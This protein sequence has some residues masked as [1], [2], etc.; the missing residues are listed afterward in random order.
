MILQLVAVLE[1]DW[2]N[3][4]PRVLIHQ[5]HST[6]TFPAVCVFAH[7]RN[8]IFHSVSLKMKVTVFVSESFNYS[9]SRL[10]QK[11]W[12]RNKLS[13]CLYRWVIELFSQFVQKCWFF[14]SFSL[15]IIYSSDLFK[16][17]ETFRNETSLLCVEMVLLSFFGSIC[18]DWTHNHAACFLGL[19]T[20]TEWLVDHFL[21]VGL[22]FVKGHTSAKFLY[23]LWLYTAIIFA[24]EKKSNGKQKQ[25]EAALFIWTQVGFFLRPYCITPTLFP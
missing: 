25:N 8:Q 14:E 19:Q 23:F 2:S 21:P 11:C 13:V 4:I 16:N 7:Y 17:T 24:N 22:N 18:F 1:S 6:E 3:S 9:L 15:W 12:F 20:M 10:A 5:F